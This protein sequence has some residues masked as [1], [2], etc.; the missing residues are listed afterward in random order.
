MANPN[1]NIGVI[2]ESN[3]SSQI[4]TGKILFTDTGKQYI[5]KTDGNK[6]KITDILFVS[7]L[8]ITGL[9]EILYIYE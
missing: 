4:T 2:N 1:I 6:L 7:S 3:L 9:T 5:V 8:P